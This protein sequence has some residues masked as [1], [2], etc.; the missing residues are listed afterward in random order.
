MTEAN[1]RRRCW[2]VDTQGYQTA[3]LVACAS[4][5]LGAIGYAIARR[6]RITRED[7]VVVGAAEAATVDS[8]TG[9]NTQASS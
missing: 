6:P 7:A 4:Y 3:F 8:H 1:A 5:F 9:R 2:L